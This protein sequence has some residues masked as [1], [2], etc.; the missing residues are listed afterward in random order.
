MSTRIEYIKERNRLFRKTGNNKCF[1]LTK[2]PFLKDVYVFYKGKLVNSGKAKC[3]IY[4]PIKKGQFVSTYYLY[5][6]GFAT[7]MKEP[8]FAI[9]LEDKLNYD[10]G[11][12]EI[13][14][15]PR[16]NAEGNEVAI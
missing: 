15:L 11:E 7:N 2:A 10:I 4:G 12:I 1:V 13:E 5:G 16:P 9:A 3:Y 14:F 8:A 6:I